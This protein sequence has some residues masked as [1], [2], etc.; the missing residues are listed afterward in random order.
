MLQNKTVKSETL[1]LLRRLQSEECLKETRL[2]G[3]T[4]L[5]LQIG[6]RISEDL[7]LFTTQEF[8]ADL[9]Q[10]TLESGYGF[11][12]RLKREQTIIGEAEGVKIDIIRH[13]YKWLEPDI[14]EQGIKM[15]GKK[16]LA[17]MKFHAIINSGTRPKDF[18]DI[19]YLSQSLSYDA[20][21]RLL[22][23]KYPSYD[24]ITAD[25]AI[26]Y[27]GDVDASA[28][29]SIKMNGARLDFERIKQRLHKM[30]DLPFKTF[31][32]P[33]LCELKTSRKMRF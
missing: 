18:I 20:M 26:T 11:I 8:D 22:I 33:P 31:S 13:P 27:F 3:G 12:T 17:A 29:Q 14:K 16:D 10:Q 28:L 5:A 9:V 6:H 25:R 2:V 32:S 4:A 24:P 1:G 7:D 15:A 30:T 21:K 23:E 19:A